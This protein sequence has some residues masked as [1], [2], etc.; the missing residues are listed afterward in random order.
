MWTFSC[1][2]QV[3]PLCTLS[4]NKA[5]L[6]PPKSTRHLSLF[7][8]RIEQQHPPAVWRIFAYD[9]L[10]K[11]LQLVSCV[12][13]HRKQGQCQHLEDPLMN[14]TITYGK[15]LTALVL[16]CPSIHHECTTNA[17]LKQR[18]HFAFQNEINIRQCSAC[19]GS[20][21]RHFHRKILSTEILS[22]Q[23]AEMAAGLYTRNGLVSY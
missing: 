14:K 22:Y 12:T 16:V 1:I 15:I 3:V 17:G 19:S 4:Y 11:H 23:R 21:S 9:R 6:G 5:C 2:C 7:I 10:H 13:F 18:L 20:A 8:S